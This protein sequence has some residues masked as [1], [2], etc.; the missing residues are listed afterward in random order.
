MAAMNRDREIL[1]SSRPAGLRVLIPGYPQWLWHQTERGAV[2]GGT[3]LAAM[4]VGLFAWGSPLG[5]AMLGLGFF[6]HVASAS[7]AIRQGAFPG[8]GRWVPT[9]SATAGLGLGCYGPAAA[10][11]VLLAWPGDRWGRSRALRGQPLRVPLVRA[12]V[13]R[14]G[15]VPHPRR[16]RLRPRPPRRPLRPVGRMVLRRGP[17]RQHAAKLASRRPRRC[18]PGPLHD[19][20]RR[21]VARLPDVAGDGLPDLLRTDARGARRRRRPS[22]GAALPG[23]DEA[24]PVLS[25][26]RDSVGWVGPPEAAQPT[27]GWRRPTWWVAPPPAGRPTRRN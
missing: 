20:A 2:L 6:A 27:I 25:G 7:D 9:V 11:A 23:V 16:Q 17:R 12:S 21:P 3:Y 4:A 15:L 19:R 1:P 5:L 8:F 14:L 18:P 10:M 13:R 22:L 26:G 24:A